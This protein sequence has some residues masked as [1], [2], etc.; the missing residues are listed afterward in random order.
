MGKSNTKIIKIPYTNYEVIIDSYDYE[1][2]SEDTYRFDYTFKFIENTKWLGITVNWN[3]L[4]SA[5]Y[6]DN[7]N[8]QNES[9]ADI[10]GYRVLVNNSLED[11]LYQFIEE[12]KPKLK[13]NNKHDIKTLP[14]YI[15]LSDEAR[16]RYT[17]IENRMSYNVEGNCLIEEDGKWVP[18]VIYKSTI[19]GKTYARSVQR[20]QDRF[21]CTL[22][23]RKNTIASIF[24]KLSPEKRAKFKVIDHT[25]NFLPLHYI[26]NKNSK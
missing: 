1:K 25:D 15:S 2:D 22:D 10:N 14:S 26:D 21:I 4:Y 11:T 3:I 18:G 5:N 16:S 19:T 17:H 9:L 20:F 24:N 6:I 13:I 8:G 12:I 7:I 23:S